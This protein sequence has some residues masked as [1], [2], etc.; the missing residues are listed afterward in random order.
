VV[1][2]NRPAEVVIAFTDALHAVPCCDRV[3]S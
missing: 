2:R 1:F 3:A